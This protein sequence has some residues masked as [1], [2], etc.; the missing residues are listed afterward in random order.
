[1]LSL[2]SDFAIEKD[3]DLAQL[4]HPKRRFSGCFLAGEKC[5]ILA[6]AAA[7]GCGTGKGQPHAPHWSCLLGCGPVCFPRLFYWSHLHSCTQQS[8]EPPPPPNPP[9]PFLLSSAMLDGSSGAEETGEERITGGKRAEYSFPA[10][11][12]INLARL[13]DLEQW[14]RNFHPEALQQPPHTF[15]FELDKMSRFFCVIEK[16]NNLDTRWVVLNYLIMSMVSSESNS[17]GWFLWKTKEWK[18]S[19]Y[20]CI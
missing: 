16:G 7:A 4:W 10:L 2:S 12:L 3:Y 19:I 13:L 5:S 14:S 1:M 11:G 8:Q 15:L 20:L 18:I 9:F 17:L 6:A